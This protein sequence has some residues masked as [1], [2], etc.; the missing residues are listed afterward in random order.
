MLACGEMLSVSAP[1]TLSTSTSTTYIA[2]DPVLCELFGGAQGL[3][4]VL[5]SW[6]KEAGQPGVI[7]ANL[8]LLVSAVAGI[9]NVCCGHC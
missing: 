8:N 4:A 5:L 3:R 2:R 6:K 7:S 1:Q 9:F